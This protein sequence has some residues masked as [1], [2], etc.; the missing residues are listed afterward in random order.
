[1]AVVVFYTEYLI[2]ISLKKLLK[3]FEIEFQSG[4]SLLIFL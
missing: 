1:M 4:L 2:L 3:I